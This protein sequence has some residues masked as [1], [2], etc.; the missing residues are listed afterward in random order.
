[1]NVFNPS[2]EQLISK[3]YIF[4]LL[5]DIYLKLNSKREKTILI[6]IKQIVC[7]L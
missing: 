6:N 4:Y 3:F 2:K 5:N 7:D 1:M